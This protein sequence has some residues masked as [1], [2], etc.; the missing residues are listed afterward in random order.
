MYLCKLLSLY[1]IGNLQKPGFNESNM[2]NIGFRVQLQFVG[3]SNIQENRV[4]LYV[5]RFSKVKVHILYTRS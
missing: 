5:V 3:V 2:T 1:S 4:M